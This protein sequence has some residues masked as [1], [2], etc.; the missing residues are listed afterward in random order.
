M[1]IFFEPQTKIFKLDTSSTSYV[2]QINKYGYLLHLYYGTLIE[3]IDLGYLS[4]TCPHASQ[5]PRVEMESETNPFFSKDTHR[6]EY[7][8]NGC[9]DFRGSALSILR[10]SGTSDTDIKYVSHKIYSGKPKIEG[11]PATYATENEATTLEILCKDNASGAEVTLFYTVFEICGAMTR[12]VI[13]KNTS[14]K[15]MDIQRVFSTCV[16]FHDASEMDFIHL[17]GNWGIERTFERAPLLHSTQSAESKR[18]CS[19]HAHNPFIALCSHDATET[20][21]DTYGFNLVYTG[22]FYASAEMDSDGGAR[23]LMGI[24]PEGFMWHL[25]PN[26]SFEAPEAV[27]VYSNEGLGGMSRIFHKLYRNNLCRGEWKN[28][29]RPILINNW[30]ATY[31]DFDEE[32]LYDI[33]KTASEL[34]IEMLVMDDGWFGNRN[35]SK[36]ALGD[37]FDN[38][39]KLKGGL[40]KLVERVNAL[41]LKFGIWFEPEMVSKDSELFRK[42]PEWALQT[43]NREMSISRHQYVLDMSRK[44]VRDYLFDCI[45][46][47]MDS[48]NI[49][50]IKWDFN[51]S[52]TEV[53][54]A[55][56]ETNRQQEVFH[57]YVLGLYELLE[58]ILTAYPHLLLEGCASGG[59]RFDPAWLYYSPQFWTSDDTDAIERLDIQY[60][61]SM[62]YPTSSVGSHVSAIPN[63]QMKRNSPLQTRGHVAMAGTFGYELD[64]T[65]LTDEEK[66]IVKTQ[67]DDYR[68]YYNVIN[69]GELYRLIS[70]W[71]NRRRCAWMYVSED[72]SE[73]LVTYVIIRCGVYERY[74][75]RL[76]GLDP[77]KRYLNEQTGQVLTGKAWMNAG[78][79]LHERLQDHTSRI[80]HLVAVE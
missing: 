76:A 19:S 44:D 26:E 32:K 71:S 1:P 33:A 5:L 55:L 66:E 10:S 50:Y 51:R 6:M 36:T 25:E 7:S 61:T 28:K 27:M 52:L 53:G 78:I 68:K 16:D 40:R 43:P 9:G 72:K 64:L 65:K 11:Q 56:L 31:F 46:K 39:E 74:Y 14:K 15:P 23:V 13:V 70:P 79:C 75:L 54:S 73:A 29:R 12:H 3:D 35:S 30:E 57:R 38:E 48:A 45:K 17:Y 49:A 60:G 20:C 21:G 34:G 18:G 77:N 63:H 67:C 24:N 37:W 58:R 42:H 80:F 47:V 8:T 69:Y 59:G 62:C 2:M 22:N 4:Y 41:G